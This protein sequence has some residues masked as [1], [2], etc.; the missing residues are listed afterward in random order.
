M[1]K[2]HLLYLLFM[3]LLS[4]LM[5]QQH[6]HGHSTQIDTLPEAKSLREIFSKGETEGHLRSY[7][8]TTLNAGSLRDYYTHALGGSLGFE[9]LPW[10]GFQFGV[11][12]IF[13][14]R[15]FSSNLNQPDPT[16]GKISKWEHELY[17]IT[18]EDNFNDLDRLEELFIT[19]RHNKG[20]F[21]YG[22]IK[23]EDSPLLNESDGRMKPFAFKGLWLNHKFGSRQ[24]LNLGWISRVS[25]RSTVE[26]YSLNE[27]LGIT[28]N[29]FQPDG[30]EADYHEHIPS[31]GI[32]SGNYNLKSNVLSFSANYWYIHRL[33]HTQWLELHYKKNELNIGLQYALQI[34]DPFQASLPYQHRYI[35]ED[36]VGQVFSSSILVEKKHA[37]VECAYTHAFASGRFLFPRELGRDQFFTSVSRARLEGFGDVDVLT[38]KGEYDFHIKHFRSSLAL[39]RLWGANTENLEFNK[40]GLDE[41]YLLNTRLHY[42]AGKL[43]EGLSLDLLYVIRKNV[44]EHDPESIFNTSDFHQINLVTNINF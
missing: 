6:G 39:Q 12:G 36:E 34:P 42:E 7:F 26:W 44:H 11:R 15:T 1:K 40:Y 24:T 38:L 2:Q 3:L 21:S 37:K 41:F 19:W 23:I 9:T 32:L 20:Y 27:A 17:D 35:Q 18:D 4:P 29:G 5:A 33:M 28:N 10:K 13:T 43:L 22:K 14:Y 31:E 16:T 25:P 8:M 30:S